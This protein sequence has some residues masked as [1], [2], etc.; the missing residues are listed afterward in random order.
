[1]PIHGDYIRVVHNGKLTVGKSG[2]VKFNEVLDF[3]EARD[4]RLIIVDRKIELGLLDNS[5]QFA[6]EHEDVKYFFGR[7]IKYALIRDEFRDYKR[8]RLKKRKKK[9]KNRIQGT[10]Q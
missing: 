4:S 5:R 3:V 9:T 2:S 8:K 1:M 10:I 6:W 7:L